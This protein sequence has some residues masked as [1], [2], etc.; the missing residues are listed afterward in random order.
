MC[1]YVCERVCERSV[2][3]RVRVGGW[4]GGSTVCVCVSTVCVCVGGGGSVCTRACV[5]AGVRGPGVSRRAC[6][7]S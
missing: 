3:V 7:W 5:L 2:C 6:V 1:D 4:V